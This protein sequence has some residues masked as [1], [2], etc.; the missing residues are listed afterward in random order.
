[1]GLDILFMFDLF[2]FINQAV[3]KAFIDKDKNRV[4]MGI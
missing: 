4:V 2:N 1:M 3:I